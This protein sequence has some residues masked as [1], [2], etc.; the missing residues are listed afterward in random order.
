MSCSSSR[1][2]RIVSDSYDKVNDK[3]TLG[4]IPYGNI[5]IQGRWTKTRYN[6]VSR[7]HFFMN[8]ESVTIAITKAPKEKYPFYEEN[9]TDE[10]FTEKFYQWEFEHYTK[11]G[12]KIE[13]INPERQQNYIIWKATGNEANTIFIYGAKNNFA[14]KFSVLKAKWSEEKKIEFLKSCLEKIK[15]RV[16]TPC[17]KPLWLIV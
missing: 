3:T 16:A 4:L 14:Y 12:Y 9:L 1:T 15:K 17:I 5:L 8:N 11:Q 7:Q 2:S 13:K 10:K 6:E